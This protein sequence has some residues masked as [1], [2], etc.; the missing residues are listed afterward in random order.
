MSD[1]VFQHA[2]ATIA[3][4]LRK[5]EE[6]KVESWHVFWKDGTDTV[7]PCS[8]WSVDELLKMSNIAHFELVKQ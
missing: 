6:P 4:K 5:Q 1:S 8:A 3:E 2:T 7:W